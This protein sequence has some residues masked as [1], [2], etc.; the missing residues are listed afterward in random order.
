MY[1]FEQ[2]RFVWLSILS[3]TSHYLVFCR[4]ELWPF[5]LIL[6]ASLLLSI[7]VSLRISLSD[8]PIFP[9]AVKLAYIDMAACICGVLASIGVYRLFFHRLRH[10]P[11]P[12]SWALS[13]FAFVNADIN[14]LRSTAVHEAHRRY[15]DIVRTGPRE[16]SINAATAIAPVMGARST[17]WRGPWYV[18]AGNA[19]SADAPRN[20]HSTLRES[21]HA[22]RRKIWDSAFSAKS[23][24][25]YEPTLIDVVDT[26]VKQL[27]LRSR[28]QETVNIDDFCCLYAYDVMSRVGFGADFG[29]LEH[30]QVTAFVKALD[31]FVAYAQ[32]IG[33][34]PYLVE[35]VALLPNPMAQLNKY[36]ES[37]LNE[38]KARKDPAP[39]IMAHLLVSDDQTN[40][41]GKSKNKDAEALSDARLMLGAGSDTAC[42]TMGVVI[43]YLM[44][45]PN[46]L[47][48]LRQELLDVFE[49]APGLLTDF[50]RMDEKTCPLLNA[51][52]NEALRLVPPV[53][54]GLQRES[55][56][57]TT[58]DVNGSRVVI[59]ANT[60]VTLPILTIQRDP[61]NF[62]PE[63]LQFRPQRWLRPE[64]EER[65]NR[66]A[67]MPFSFG[68]TFCPG[69]VL[70]YMELRLVIANLVRRFDFVPAEG[71]DAQKFKDGL[72]DAFVVVRK[73]KL[74]VQ[75]RLHDHVGP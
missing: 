9:D 56:V 57:P 5:Q 53:P 17:F 69:K 60:V 24:K 61:R 23:L 73:H 30:G 27:E 59:P 8:T 52:I 62:S 3:V 55:P 41:G 35:I 51:I 68:K 44:E 39:D 2:H 13:K 45:S 67:F 37:I 11:G 75:I 48:E 43:F 74:P 19:R 20:L 21:D 38:R 70:A 40:N 18:A 46:I 66:T 36:M 63:P 49:D 31:H 64:N 15:G 25:S 12:K 50:A 14:G 34:L 54:G 58:V 26:M 32:L 6:L 28:R 65:L 10:F 33:N 1:A 16:I 4:I 72:V 47:A 7:D 42:I 71:Y 29:L 22:A